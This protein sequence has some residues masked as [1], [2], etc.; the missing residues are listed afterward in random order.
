MYY[1]VVHSVNCSN[2]YLQ[3]IREYKQLCQV[4]PELF[5]SYDGHIVL[6]HPERGK[7]PDG[8]VD[9]LNSTEDGEASEE[10]HRSPNEAKLSLQGHL[11]V[12]FNLVKGRRVKEDLNEVD[13]SL[14]R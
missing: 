9:D 2:I 1:R 8:K 10:A 13:L 14:L 7:E 5:L 3:N 6:L 4:I 11:L 12:L